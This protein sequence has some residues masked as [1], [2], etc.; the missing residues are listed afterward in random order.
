MLMAKIQHYF[1]LELISFLLIFCENLEFNSRF[2]QNQE[3]YVSE[4]DARRVRAAAKQFPIVTIL[5]P[6]Q[7][8]KT[9]LVRQTF[10]DKP[11]VNMELIHIRE[12]ASSDPVSFFRTIS[13]RSYFRR[14]SRSS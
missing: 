3:N 11:Y 13:G 6:R 10:P 12:L 7:S 14:D 9:T 8:G 4:N 1:F 5:G 2:S